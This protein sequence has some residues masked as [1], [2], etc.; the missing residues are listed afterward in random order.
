MKVHTTLS[1]DVETATMAQLIAKKMD[2]TLSAFIQRSLQESIEEFQKTATAQSS[3]S[4]P[5]TE[6]DQYDR[7]WPNRPDMAQVLRDKAKRDGKL[8]A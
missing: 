2:M 5:A 6:P 7:A 4:K 1:L 3:A 8:K